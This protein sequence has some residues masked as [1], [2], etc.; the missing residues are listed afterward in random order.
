[1]TAGN[2]W[3]YGSDPSDWADDRLIGYKVE[4]TDG[5]VGKIDAASSEVGAQ[6]MVVKTGLPV[7]GE[8]V[9]LPAG[10]IDRVDH[11]EEKVYVTAT[12]DQIK[13]SPSYNESAQDDITYRQN[14]GDYYGGSG[15]TM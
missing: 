11:G 13:D 1:M 14:L 2:M 12:K 5:S 6:C 3:E 10:L 8:K 7:I 9:M 15:R 4:A